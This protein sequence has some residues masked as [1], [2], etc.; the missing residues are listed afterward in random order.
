MP[1]LIG[2]DEAGYGPNLGPMV[3]TVVAL[4][5]DAEPDAFDAWQSFDGVVTRS[6][7]VAGQIQIADSKE[8]YSPARGLAALERGVQ[9]ALA[10]AALEGFDGPPPAD[11]TRG[12]GLCRSF[13]QLCRRIVVTPEA[14]LMRDPWYQEA[15]LPLPRAA[16]LAALQALTSSW[17]S[18]CQ[19]CGVALAGIWSD[20]VPP[21]RFNALSRMHQSKGRALSWCSMRLLR[22]IFSRLPINF[23][24]AEEVLVVADKHG[25]RNRYLQFLPILCESRFIRSTGES[26]L[27]SRYAI[28]PVRVWFEA[29]A[30]Q[31]FPVALASMVSK[32][33][34][35]L[36]MELFNAFWQARLPGL[37]STA[38]YPVDARRFRKQIAETQLS[39]GISD[40]VLWRDR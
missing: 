32:Y 13:R 23:E 1:Y 26:R 5:V 16:D 3:I 17:R 37:T 18:R 29:R 9:C 33:L 22:D 25:G 30:E 10:L 2:M 38:G 14:E 6:S 27:G 35:E 21:A 39:L 40:D 24:N 7:A 8:V 20:V 19:Q 12:G 11:I 15:D 4:R 34:R 36:S 28:G 31:H